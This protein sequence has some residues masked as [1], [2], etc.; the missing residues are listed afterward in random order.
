[1]HVHL[2]QHVPYEGLA[3]I[4]PW[5][6]DRGATITHTPFFET[7][8]LPDLTE[9]DFLI[10][11]GGPMGVGD[12]DEYP[13]L[14]KEKRYIRDFIS[15]GRPVLGICLGAQLIAAAMGARVTRS[16]ERE[17]GWLPLEG[18]PNPGGFSLPSFFTAF[19]WHG[20]TFELP[21]GAVQL[22]SSAACENQAFQLG[23]RV[24]GLQFHL[25]TTLDS[26][27]ELVANCGREVVPGSW[28][29]GTA[30]ILDPPLGALSSCHQRL[31]ELL[32][33]LTR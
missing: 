26:A 3:A 24:V 10:A 23:E 32:R 5:L 30:Q 22:A 16:P 18:L 4:E 29:Q 7:D 27:R 19:Q 6:V 25:E 13:W 1:M 2:L 15:T 21:D 33:F 17:V 14:A 9:P 12:E 31:S 11:M 20:D 28:V 8:S